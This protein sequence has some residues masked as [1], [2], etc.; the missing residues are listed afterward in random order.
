MNF[1]SIGK[2]AAA[3]LAALSIAIAVPAQENFYQGKTIQL[4]VGYSAGGGYDI[5]GRTV[6]RHIGK[7]IPG[8]PNVIVRNVPG[9]GS[10]VAMNQIANTLPKDGTVIGTVSR[11]LPYEPLFGNEQVQFDPQEV[12]WLG[13]VASEVS[14][15]VVSTNSNIN[16]WEDLYDNSLLVGATGSG[17]DSNVF[18]RVLSDT[19]GFQMNVVAGY[20]GSSDIVLAFERGEVESIC[21][22]SY[23]SNKENRDALIENGQ[24]RII[25]QMALQKHPE[26]PDIPL[27]IDLAETE[28]QRQALTLLF[29]R[30][31]MGRPFVA[32]PGVPEDRLAILRQALRDTTN[33]PEFLQDAANQS[34]EIDFF[35]GED[36]HELIREAYTYPASVVDVIRDAM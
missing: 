3:G 33:D 2:Y 16:T 21:S 30:Q 4:I 19:L 17:G 18:P 13:S 1:N 20:P 22:W 23:S 6:A 27:I 25:F 7:H 28:E 24:A 36:I 29:G 31:Q 10:M 35:S 12:N 32:P 15:C 14:L 8:N 11:G 5:F 26:L 9:A 34:L